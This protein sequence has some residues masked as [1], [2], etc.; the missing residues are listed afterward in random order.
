[1]CAEARDADMLLKQDWLMG[2]DGEVRL[3]LRPRWPEREQQAAPDMRHSGAGL[4]RPRP[5]Q[6]RRADGEQVLGAGEAGTAARAPSPSA[7][8]SPTPRWASSSQHWP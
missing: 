8:A 2:G 3:S 7:S 4:A 1:M 5:L 6:R